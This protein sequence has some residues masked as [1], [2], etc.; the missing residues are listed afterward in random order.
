MT[1]IIH[2]DR[3]RNLGDLRTKHVVVDLFL[4]N[5]WHSVLQGFGRTSP[6]GKIE[7]LAE[8]SMLGSRKALAIEL[9]NRRFLSDFCLNC[10]ARS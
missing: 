6:I 4:V 3:G 1:P 7:N 2:E 8:G 10:R 9:V 5:M